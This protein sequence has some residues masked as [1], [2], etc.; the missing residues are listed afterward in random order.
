MLVC[1]RDFDSPLCKNRRLGKV[2]EFHYLLCGMSG[3]VKTGPPVQGLGWL[4]ARRR[5]SH[6][7]ASKGA[8]SAFVYIQGSTPGY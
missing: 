7:F 5:G 6:V 1:G 2:W 4:A 3:L 8:F